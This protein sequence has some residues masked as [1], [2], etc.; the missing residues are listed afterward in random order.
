MKCKK[1]KKLISKYFDNEINQQEVKNLFE[2][3]KICP[4]CEKEFNILSTIYQNLPQY[5]NIDISTD[6]NTRL[7]MR[8]SKQMKNQFNIF[9]N[10]FYNLRV[11]PF[12]ISL[13]GMF[14]I[15]LGVIFFSQNRNNLNHFSYQLYPQEEIDLAMIDFF[16]E[17]IELQ[18]Y[19]DGNELNLL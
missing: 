15:V 8:L 6:F 16:V 14:L 2:H 19:V 10:I 12:L 5:E 17:Y 7:F 9:D 18:Q 3:I 4:L 11:K 1:I 13:A